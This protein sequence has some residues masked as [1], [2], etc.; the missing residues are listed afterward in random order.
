MDALGINLPGLT[1]QVI[2]FV[3]LLGLLYLLAY[4]PILK[5]IDQRAARIKDSLDEAERLNE[6]S[7]KAQK[8][9][10]ELQKKARQ[11]SQAVLDEARL[12]AERYREEEKEKA[13]K[14]VE[15]FLEKARLQIQNEKETSLDEVRGKFADLAVLAAERVIQNTVD[16]KIHKE[17]IDKVLDENAELLGK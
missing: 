9:I 6:K 10:E 5:V 7:A 15:D 4:K 8:G 14:E 2:N 11:E 17:I 3:I 13:R 12:A 1:V 16:K